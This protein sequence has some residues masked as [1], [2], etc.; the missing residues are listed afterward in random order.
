M[1]KTILKKSYLLITLFSI[2]YLVVPMKS[3]VF[4]QEKKNRGDVIALNESQPGRDPS[5]KDTAEELEDLRRR[6]EDLEK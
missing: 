6:I 3:F 5:S 1:K 2:L 4:S